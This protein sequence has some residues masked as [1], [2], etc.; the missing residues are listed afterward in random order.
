SAEVPAS[1]LYVGTR[2]EFE[3]KRTISRLQEMQSHDYLA[4]SHKA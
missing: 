1:E 2:V 3:F 4:L